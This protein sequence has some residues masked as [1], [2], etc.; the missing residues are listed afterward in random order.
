MALIDVPPEIMP[1]L[2]VVTLPAAR[3]SACRYSAQVRRLS[4]SIALLAPKSAKL[5]PP[6]VSAVIRYRAEPTARAQT[7]V[8]WSSSERNALTRGAKSRIMALQPLRLPSPSSQLLQTN[9]TPPFGRRPSRRILSI[10]ISMPATLAVSSPTPGQYS[11]PFS[12]RIGIGSRSGNTVSI[13]AITTAISPLSS[14][15]QPHRTFFA[16]SISAEN[17]RT[18]SHSL[19]KAARRSSRW[20]GAGIRQSVLINSRVSLCAASISSSSAA[21]SSRISM[22]VPPFVFLL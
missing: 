18:S 10:R 3:G 5:C 7:W 6:R 16:S 4:T 20:L 19:M 13:C 12:S 9:S 15:P 11:R 1:T 22:P 17:P 14:T 21:L 8:D 2:Y